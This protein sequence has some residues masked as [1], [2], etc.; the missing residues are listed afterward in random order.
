VAD[1][2]D[3]EGP[4]NRA[5]RELLNKAANGQFPAAD[6]STTHLPS[7]SS[8]ADAVLSFFGHHV[9]ASDVDPAWLREWTDRDPFALS[10]VRCLAAFAGQAKVQPGIFD[11]VFAAPGEGADVDAV[12]LL[13]I[14]ERRHPRVQRALQYRDPATMRVFADPRGNSVLII[15]RGLAGRLEAAYE[16]DSA[17]RGRGLGKALVV[18]ARRLANAGEPIFMQISPGNVW[19]M[20]AVSADPAWRVIGS[21]VLFHRSPATGLMD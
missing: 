12:G 6:F 19:S 18:A 10:D 16:V 11:A 2:F 7:P 13:E 20:R 4:R 5:L 1:L 8:P 21:E 17:S 9:I 3:G 14:N 15:G